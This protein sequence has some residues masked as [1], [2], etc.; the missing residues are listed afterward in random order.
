MFLFIY[1]PISL[2]GH[3]CEVCVVGCIG[4]TGLLYQSK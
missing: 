3:L 4:F 2:N 1:F